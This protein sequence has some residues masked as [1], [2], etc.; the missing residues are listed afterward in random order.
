MAAVLMLLG[1]FFHVDQRMG[2]V[3]LA[4][5]CERSA[6]LSWRALHDPQSGCHKVSSLKWLECLQV[7]KASRTKVSKLRKVQS[8]PTH[9]CDLPQPPVKCLQ[10]SNPARTT[11]SAKL[12]WSSA[13]HHCYQEKMVP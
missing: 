5:G 6:L 4:Q 8:L 10:T 2:A 9:P 7:L 1:T 13:S 12:R 11:P 3:L